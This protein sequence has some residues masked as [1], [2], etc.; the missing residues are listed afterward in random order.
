IQVPIIDN[1]P[2]E[3]DETFTVSLRNP[4]TLESLG[5][6][7]TTTVTVQDHS[8]IPTMSILDLSVVEGNPGTTTDVLFRVE[9][10]AATG[11]AVGGNFATSNLS[12]FGGASCNDQG[13]DYEARAGTF[14]FATGSTQTNIP[15]KICGDTSAEANETFRVILSNV[16]GATLLP[17]AQGLGT[18]VDDDVLG[19]ILEESGP[20]SA[21]AAALDQ[22]LGLRDPFRI[23]TIPDWFA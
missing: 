18:I 1:E 5:A 3:P 6:P 14:S 17:S 4:P 7:S 20:S 12:A 2:T 11:R 13:V 21:Q 8:T 10:S 9:I 19:L 16:S 22:L 15:V 23:V